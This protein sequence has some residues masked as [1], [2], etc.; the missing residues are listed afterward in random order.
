MNILGCLR[1]PVGFG[2][3][4]RG[5]GLNEGLDLRILPSDGIYKK[6]YFYY[7]YVLVSV[8]THTWNSTSVIL[9]LYS[10]FFSNI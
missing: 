7:Y 2:D 10:W 9:N 5:L 3:L 6:F 1:I 4:L 8:L